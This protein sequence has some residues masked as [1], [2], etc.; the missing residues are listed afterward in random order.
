MIRLKKELALNVGNRYVSIIF[1]FT[2]L[3]Q[4][5]RLAND[6]ILV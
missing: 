4:G 6:R 5:I 1:L 2:L 3:R